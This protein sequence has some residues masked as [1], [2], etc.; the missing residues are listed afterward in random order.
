MKFYLINSNDQNI[1]IIIYEFKKDETLDDI[2]QILFNDDMNSEREDEEKNLSEIFKELFSKVTKKPTKINKNIYIPLFKIIS[3]RLVFRPSVFSNV[4]LENEKI[5]KKY[6]I[7]CLNYIEELTFGIDESYVMDF[8][9]DIGENIII[10]NDF[11]ISLVNND[12][13]YELQ[14][15]TISTFLVQKSYWIKSS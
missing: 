3:N 5:Q 6:K 2:K 1:S 4:I 10:Q 13:I 15:P 11:I 12:L 14:I 8:D 9:V 7:N